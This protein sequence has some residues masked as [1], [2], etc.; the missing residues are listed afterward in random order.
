M[1]EIYDTK[2]KRMKKILENLNTPKTPEEL[3]KIVYPKLKMVNLGKASISEKKEFRNKQR[4]IY[5]D[6]KS[7]RGLNLVDYDETRGTYQRA[8][9][10]KKI[11][12]NKAELDMAIKHAKNLIENNENCL[13]YTSPSPRD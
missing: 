10:K 9:I 1:K 6:L 11:F 4:N 7:L 3:T 12:R 8:G 13:L 2:T 5:N